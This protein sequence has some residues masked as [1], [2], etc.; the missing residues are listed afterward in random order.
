MKVGIIIQ[1]NEKWQIVIPKHIRDS[2]GIDDT[3][4]FNITARG[5]GVY[6]YPVT[7]VITSANSDNSYLSILAKTRGSWKNERGGQTISKRNLEL[8]ASHKRKKKW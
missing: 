5:K 1:P 2:I 4:P 6:L 8:A 7:D 3:V